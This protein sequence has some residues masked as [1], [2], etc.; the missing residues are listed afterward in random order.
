MRAISIILAASV[1]LTACG[2]GESRLNPFN[3]FG[4]SSEEQLDEAAEAAR[5]SLPLVEEV[6]ALK[7]DALP[8][9]AII[10]VV[11]RPP[12]QG[13]WD[14][15][16]TRVP[17]ISGALVLNFEIASPPT[18]KAAGTQPSR[19]VLAGRYI[20]TQDLGGATTIIVQGARNQRSV[21]RQ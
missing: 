2:L 17:G 20:S 15:E 7:I 19:E 1:A 6:V 21:R 4:R 5:A 10:S 11:G 18:P 14:A 8:S 16:L 9:G 3:W 13:Y 12:T